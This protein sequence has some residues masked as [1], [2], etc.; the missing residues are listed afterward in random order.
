M[1]SEMC[2][3]CLRVY[4]VH[5]EI[6]ENALKGLPASMELLGFLLFCL[7]SP[8]LGLGGVNLLN[9]STP[10]STQLQLT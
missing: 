10:K 3:G 1:V 9:S 7:F 5:I 4:L 6:L 2:V 8:V